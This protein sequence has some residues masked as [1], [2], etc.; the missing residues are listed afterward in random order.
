MWTL[1][2]A[3]AMA[4]A[5]AAA[6]AAPATVVG[7]GAQT[8]VWP[9]PPPQRV[10]AGFAPPAHDWL[11]GHRG[12]DLAAVPGESVVAAGDGRVSYAGTI[13]GVGV[14]AI[15]HAGGL[16]TTYEPVARSVR[17][18]ELVRGGERI[19]RI[20]GRLGHCAQTCLHWG[21]RRGSAYLDPLALLGEVRIRLLPVPSPPARSPAGLALGLPA[22]AAGLVTYRRVRRR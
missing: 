22:A 6:P 8:W 12:V 9:L 3:L 19:G 15:R 17:A 4:A 20:A 13:A 7:P 1:L 14:V 18:G 11:P 21:L 5:P 16:E 2:A 10:L